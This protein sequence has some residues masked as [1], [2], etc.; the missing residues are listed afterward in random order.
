MQDITWSHW[1][2]SALEDITKTF[3]IYYMCDDISVIQ[4]GVWKMQH[5]IVQN[6]GYKAEAPYFSQD[7][8]SS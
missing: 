4:D 1:V 3:R 2:E 7:I 8:Y 5:S 6:M